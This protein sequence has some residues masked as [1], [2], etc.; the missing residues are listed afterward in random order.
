MTNIANPSGWQIPSS[1]PAVHWGRIVVHVF[2]LFC[3]HSRALKIVVPALG[4]LVAFD[5]IFDPLFGK[6]ILN[7]VEIR[8]LVIL[9]AAFLT[10]LVSGKIRIAEK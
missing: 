7:D 2:P 1:P 6:V 10:K 5:S 9:R 8:T 4:V 3:A